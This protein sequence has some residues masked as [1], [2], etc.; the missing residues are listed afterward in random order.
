MRW[1]LA[2]SL[3]FAAGCSSEPDFDE[4]YADAEKQLR[5][6]AAEIDAEIDERAK[7]EASPGKADEQ[8]LNTDGATPDAPSRKAK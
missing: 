8:R 5:E 4:R 6:K 1:L 2:T 7:D 3:L